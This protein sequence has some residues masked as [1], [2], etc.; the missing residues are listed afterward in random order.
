MQITENAS[1]MN[2]F[3][4]SENRMKEIDDLTSVCVGTVV[5]PKD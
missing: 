4:I 2:D 5:R 1:R 3:K